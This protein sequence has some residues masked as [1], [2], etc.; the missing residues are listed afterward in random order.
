MRS[1]QRGG[2]VT[3]VNGDWIGENP[4]GE[5]DADFFNALGMEEE[6]PYN[7]GLRA[8]LDAQEEAGVDANDGAAHRAGYYRMWKY[9]MED[10]GI[11]HSSKWNKSNQREIV[12]LLD[13]II[14]Q[15]RADL[16]HF[17]EEGDRRRFA[18]RTA[19]EEGHTRILSY[20]TQLRNLVNEYGISDTYGIDF[21]QHDPRS[22][23]D[24]GADTPITATPGY[25]EVARDIA[26][27]YN[28]R[29]GGRRRPKRRATKRRSGRRRLSRH[30]KRGRRTARRTR[31]HGRR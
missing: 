28:P 24:F 14:A 27:E 29:V 25:A 9:P 16:D 6:G 21:D 30:R 2:T 13:A 11:M 18:G 8:E 5:V 3:Y 10:K 31:R 17:L 26:A 15:R 23:H 4:T 1:L 12:A 7:N 19:E 20:V 22:P